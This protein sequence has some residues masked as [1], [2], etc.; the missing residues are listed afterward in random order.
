MV[1]AVLCGFEPVRL[2]EREKEEDAERER[3]RKKPQEEGKNMLETQKHRLTGPYFCQTVRNFNI[4]PPQTALNLTFSTEPNFLNLVTLETAKQTEV[5]STNSS[6]TLQK[7][8]FIYKLISFVY[9]IVQ[10]LTK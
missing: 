6:N 10:N 3:V 5:R 4:K 7:W 2:Q 8:N 9:Q 1:A